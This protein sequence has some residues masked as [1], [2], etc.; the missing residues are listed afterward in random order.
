MNITVAIS[1][2]PDQTRSDPRLGW[3]PARFPPGGFG[4]TN[5]ID[6][7][8]DNGSLDGCSRVCT[9][10]STVDGRRLPHE[11][12]SERWEIENVCVCVS[13]RE[14]DFW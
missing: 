11:R 4:R 6:E 9:P 10:H 12:E 1:G 7:R 13:E 2:R 8:D 5:Q 14:E 3:D